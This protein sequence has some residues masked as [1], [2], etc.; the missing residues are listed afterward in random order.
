[1]ENKEIRRKNLELLI[2]RFKT[3]KAVADAV[4]TA[5]NHISMIQRG[6][7]G[8]GDKLA[9]KFE[10]KLGLTHGWMDAT[11]TTE[12]KG[13]N[14][15][16]TESPEIVR[17]IRAFSWLT[18]DQQVKTLQVLEAKAQTNMAISKQLGA[19]WEFKSDD[20]VGNHISPA[21]KSTPRKQSKKSPPKREPGT[22]MDDFLDD[23]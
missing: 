15:V 12:P 16:E 14:S 10:D 21:P 18:D 5:A 13:K 23:D 1:M 11:H 20:H 22:A 8:L 7:R 3:A 9:R 4:D 19:R 6:E 17:L 2:K